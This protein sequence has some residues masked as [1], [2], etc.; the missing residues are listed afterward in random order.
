MFA[1]Q[2]LANEQYTSST[3]DSEI[4]AAEGPQT[5]HSI[6]ITTTKPNALIEIIYNGLLW[7]YQSDKILLNVEID[8]VEVDADSEWG[9]AIYAT[10]LS[11]LRPVNP[12]FF[13]RIA[14]PGT[15]TIELTWETTGDTVKAGEN[16]YNTNCANTGGRSQLKIIQH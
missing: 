4:T 1:E 14:T 2:V 8:G 16:C 13:G 15:H 6:E 9:M 3:Y 10:A 5:L 12:H 11:L 7:C